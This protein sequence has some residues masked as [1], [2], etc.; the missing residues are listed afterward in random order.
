MGIALALLAA[1]VVVYFTARRP[2]VPTVMLTVA[3]AA[4]SIIALLAFIA[5]Q[6]GS[7][8]PYPLPAVID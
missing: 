4:V 6:T 2:R 1:T 7:W 5:M 3:I 8:N